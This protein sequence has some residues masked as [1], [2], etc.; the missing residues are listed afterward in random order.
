L[1]STMSYGALFA[2]PNAYSEYDPELS[3]QLR[4]WYSFIMGLAFLCSSTCVLLST[5]FYSQINQLPNDKTIT[6]FLF[7]HQSSFG[8]TTT[9]FMIAI[10]LLL[11]ASFLYFVILF[12]HLAIAPWA[13]LFLTTIFTVVTIRLFLSMQKD[14]I[15]LQ[16]Q[17]MQEATYANNLAGD[18]NL[19]IPNVVGIS[20]Q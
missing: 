3:D 15:S 13:F 8:Y 7:K 4:K 11:L 17:A 9:F 5:L 6:H 1:V 20:P 14:G 12:G 18:E 16:K 19:N 2:S 10:L